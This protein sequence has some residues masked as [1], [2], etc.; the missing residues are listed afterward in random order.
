[1][2]NMRNNTH[3]TP[4]TRDLIGVFSVGTIAFVYSTFFAKNAKLRCVLSS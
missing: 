2:K 3:M 1:M 4:R